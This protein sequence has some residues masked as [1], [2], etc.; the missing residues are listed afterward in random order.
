MLVQEVQWNRSGLGAVCIEALDSSSVGEVV[1]RPAGKERE[2]GVWVLGQR[3][4]LFI[5]GRCEE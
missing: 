1:V 2:I 4:R 5:G 3:E